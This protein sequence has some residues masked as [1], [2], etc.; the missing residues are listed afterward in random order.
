MKQGLPELRCALI[1]THERII[2]LGLLNNTVKLNNIQEQHTFSIQFRECKQQN[3]KLEE[4]Q[5]VGC[6]YLP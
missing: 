3:D 4:L 1:R 2:F 5:A 6:K